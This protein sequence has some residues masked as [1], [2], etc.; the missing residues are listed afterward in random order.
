MKRFFALVV[1]ATTALSFQASA[2]CWSITDTYTGIIQP[3]IE[4]TAYGPFTITAANGCFSANIDA[5]ISA[6]D[7]G[8]PPQL[9]IEREVGSTWQRVAGNTGSNVLF[10]GEFGS[11]RVRLKNPDAAPKV[12]LGTVKYGR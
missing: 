12:Y 11:Y 6:V 3:E 10:S 9:T 5:T 2:G 7:R 4:I 1:L 8:R